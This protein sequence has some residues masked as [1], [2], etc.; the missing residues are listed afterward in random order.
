MWL[1]FFEADED[2][3]N[4]DASNEESKLMKYFTLL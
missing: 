4:K 2:K 1:T 3:E